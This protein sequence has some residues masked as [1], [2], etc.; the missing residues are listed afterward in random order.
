M[1]QINLLGVLAQLIPIWL[2]PF[3]HCSMTTFL[4]LGV[5]SL[6]DIAVFS[7][8]IVWQNLSYTQAVNEDSP[9]TQPEKSLISMHVFKKSKRFMH[10]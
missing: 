2:F 7:S 3:F 1:L 5:C 6:F 9:Q 10:F 8:K 4:Q